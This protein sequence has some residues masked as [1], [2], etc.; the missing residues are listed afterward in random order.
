M[1]ENSLVEIPVNK[2][3]ALRN[4]FKVEWPMHIVAFSL[5]DNLISRFSNNPK[6][7]ESAKVYC[8]NGEWESDG[9]FIAMMVRE[10]KKSQNYFHAHQYF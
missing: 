6:S 2:L 1:S 9:T 5:I 4:K 8:L 3:P 7:I 10:K